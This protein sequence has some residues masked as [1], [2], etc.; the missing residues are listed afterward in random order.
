MRTTIELPDE[1]HH[2]LKAKA[3]LKGLSVRELVM[4]FIDQGL[5]SFISSPAELK[6]RRQP[7]PVIIH[8]T[9]RPIL[10]VKKSK[11][12]QIEE[13]EDEAKYS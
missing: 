2:K 6:K 7:P 10:P 4:K 1:L 5:Q 13:M 3:A 11:L 12:R 8:P 9:G